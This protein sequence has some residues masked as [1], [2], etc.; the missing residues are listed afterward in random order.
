M[1]KY[2]KIKKDKPARLEFFKG[3]RQQGN[4]PQGKRSKNDII[5]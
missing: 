4:C 3:K 1:Q 2:T 5:E